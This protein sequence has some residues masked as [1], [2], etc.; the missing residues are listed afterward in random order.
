MRTH[1]CPVR[2]ALRPCRARFRSQAAHPPPGIVHL[3]LR[4][5]VREE[6]N[7]RNAAR[8][9]VWVQSVVSY[10]VAIY[11]PIL[12]AYLTANLHSC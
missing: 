8:G 6:S 5:L 3:L 2:N 4:A 12:L 1:N 7:S 10:S 9:N 11:C